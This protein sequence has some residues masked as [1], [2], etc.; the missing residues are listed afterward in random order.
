[1]AALPARTLEKRAFGATR[2]RR[3][4]HWTVGDAES[5]DV[6]VYPA[7]RTR[8]ELLSISCVNRTTVVTAQNFSAIKQTGL[9]GSRNQNTVRPYFETGMPTTAGAGLFWPDNTAIT[10]RA[11]RP[12]Q[13]AEWYYGDARDGLR[14]VIGANLTGTV[15]IYVELMEEDVDFYKSEAHSEELPVTPA[16]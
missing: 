5:V 12:V 11:A 6:Q 7:L 13:S 15:D 9:V 10:T 2:V 4:L 3:V 8:W 1:M 14:I 16:A